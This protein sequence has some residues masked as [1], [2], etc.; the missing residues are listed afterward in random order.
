MSDE[1]SVRARATLEGN[2]AVVRSLLR[3]PME[4]GLGKDA[5]G[6]VIP[7]HHLSLIELRQNGKVVV[8]AH[9]GPGVARD[10][11]IGWRVPGA[12]AGDTV[13]LHLED[14]KGAKKTLELKI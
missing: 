9:V 7:A 2:V 8:R 11:A 6:A 14:N 13:S 1:I 12:K 5:G 4:N 3:H 10:P